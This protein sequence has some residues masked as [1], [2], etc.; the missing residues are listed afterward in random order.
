MLR[1]IGEALE[2]L[3]PAAP[4]GADLEAADAF[5]WHAEGGWLEP[6][7]EVNRVELA[8][9]K[10]IEGQRDTLLENT[11]RFVQGLP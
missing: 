3:A 4:G 1:R 6:V 10:G 2:R 5:A 8:L 7:A 11:R 9:L